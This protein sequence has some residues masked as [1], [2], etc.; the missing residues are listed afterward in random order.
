METTSKMDASPLKADIA[1][2]PSMAGRH[3]FQSPL[4]PTVPPCAVAPAT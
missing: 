1:E 4:S 2:H 3:L